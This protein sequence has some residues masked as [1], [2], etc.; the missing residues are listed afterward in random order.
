VPRRWFDTD[1]AAAWAAEYRERI[2]AAEAV[3]ATSAEGEQAKQR[4]RIAGLKRALTLGPD[5]LRAA[6]SKAKTSRKLA[7]LQAG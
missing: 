5:G 1:A 4:R 7:R 6:A 2:A 3:L